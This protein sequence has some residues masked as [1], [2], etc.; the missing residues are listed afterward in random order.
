MA[1]WAFIVDERSPVR[2]LARQ[3]EKWRACVLNFIVVI[4]PTVTYNF[5]RRGA[6]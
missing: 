3:S 2:E 6:R 4:H 5:A 1:V